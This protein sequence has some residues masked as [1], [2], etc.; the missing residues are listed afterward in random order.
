MA[1]ETPTD[2]PAQFREKFANELEALAMAGPCENAGYNH[3]L[4]LANLIL[5]MIAAEIKKRIGPIT[6]PAL[7]AKLAAA[8]GDMGAPVTIP[9]MPASADVAAAV[10]RLREALTG[11]VTPAKA[12][13]IQTLDQLATA[14]NA[15]DGE[16]LAGR[17]LEHNGH[18]RLWLV[19]PPGP[20]GPGKWRCVID[21]ID[22]EEFR[23][24]KSWFVAAMERELRLA[25][26]LNGRDDL[27]GPRE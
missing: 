1:E 5:A 24:I 8:F 21:G 15:P 23:Q 7:S 27:D 13:A 6:F 3:G 11:D 9:T 16:E 22:R 19:I 17:Y 20:D 10:D 4:I 25:H 2:T 18:S 14:E 12:E 26:G